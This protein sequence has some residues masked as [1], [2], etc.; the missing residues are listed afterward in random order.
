MT[1]DQT[2]RALKMYE[3]DALALKGLDQPSGMD[4]YSPFGPMIGKSHLPAY[5]ID[6]LNQFADGAFAEKPEGGELI[7]PENVFGAGGDQSL[8]QFLANQ[9]IGYVQSIERSRVSR[10]G[11]ETIWI[12]SQYADTPSPMHFH[13]LKTPEIDTKQEEKNYIGGRKAGY[14][15]F[16]NGNKQPFN[17]SL[18]SFK[19]VVGDL[20]VFPGWLMHGA[21]AFLG[22]G[23]RRSLA[24]NAQISR[25]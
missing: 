13:F 21:E 22:T 14:L 15:N 7:V 16:I 5:L 1:D 8:G 11:F 19:P 25:E 9:I 6:Q 20:Y 12:V 17:K 4:V 3:A 10:L 23:E 2:T 24:F 18:I